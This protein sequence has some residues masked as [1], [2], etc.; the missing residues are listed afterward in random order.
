MG[1]HLKQK[2][3]SRISKFIWHPKQMHMIS[4]DTLQNDM[5]NGGLEMPNLDNINQAILTERIVKVLNNDPPWKGM[6]IYRLGIHLRDLD[7]QFVSSIFAH[8]NRMDEV[9]QTISET[10]RVL[11]NTVLDWTKDNFKSIKKRLNRNNIYKKC[12]VNRNYDTTW[13]E[14]R[15]STDNRRRKDIAYLIAHDALPIRAVLKRRNVINEDH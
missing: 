4:Y 12:D 14:I 8:S 10:Y 7:R 11:K 5:D 9:S 2:V 3:Q 13:R 1:R 15:T 6:F